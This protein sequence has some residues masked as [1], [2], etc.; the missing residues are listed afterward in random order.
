MQQIPFSLFF[1]FVVT[2]CALL[3]LL[4]C[5]DDL[6]RINKSAIIDGLKELQQD[7]GR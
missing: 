7:N 6:S 1:F 5:G 4:I 2:Q 3:I